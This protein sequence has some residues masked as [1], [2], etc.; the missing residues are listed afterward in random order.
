MS[1]ELHWWSTLRLAAAGGWLFLAHASGA[2]SAVRER[3]RPLQLAWVLPAPAAALAA[4][5]DREAVLELG[6]DGQLR[7]WELSQ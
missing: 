4:L 5:G 6:L 1:D 2:V 7:R 3:P